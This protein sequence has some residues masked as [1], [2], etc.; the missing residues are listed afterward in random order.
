MFGKAPISQIYG[1]NNV[2]VENNN[3]LLLRFMYTHTYI[4]LYTPSKEHNPVG[5]TYK[6]TA[7]NNYFGSYMSFCVHQATD[8]PMYV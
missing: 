7:D 8:V 3:Y 2:A 5:M 6:C 4:I 1:N